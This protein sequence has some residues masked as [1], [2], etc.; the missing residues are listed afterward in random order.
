MKGILL[1][2]GLGNRLFP[3]TKSLSKQILPV[4]DK[5][6]IYY[7]LSV[8]MLADV[9]DIAIVTKEDDLL[10][11]SNLLGN[12]SDLGINI[13]YFVQD[14][15][16][17]IPEAFLICEKFIE[18]EKV[19][20]ILGDNI[21]YSNGFIN[22]LNDTKKNSGATIF[23]YAVQNPCDFGIVNIN[24]NGKIISLK[25]KPKNSLSN[26]AITGMYFFD[27]NVNNY[28][29]K[30][31]PSKRGELEIIDLIKIYLKKSELKHVR[32]GR[33]FAWLDTGTS[34][35]LIEAGKFIEIIEKRQGLKIGCIEEIAYRKRLITK[36]EFKKLIY[37]YPD[38]EYK[39]YLKKLV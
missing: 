29:R 24:R 12:G 23:S 17:G 37:K 15:P 21:F 7:P 22:I 27:E 26:L 9:T 4:F 25:E 28:S 30:L 18:K 20:M 11:F 2:G 19:M 3:L 33:G 1:A 14:R 36:S 39:L 35:S 16:T 5:P 31:K 32:L 34:N 6:M 10:S 13:K 8:L 38:C